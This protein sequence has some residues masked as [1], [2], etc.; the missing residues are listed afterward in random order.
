MKKDQYRQGDVFLEK[1]DKIPSEAKRRKSDVLV[2]GEA[3]G[4]AHRL[5]NGLI[6]E[7][8]PHLSSDPGQMFV[9][10][11]QNAVLFH[12]EHGQIEIEVGFYI[13]VR[14]R[15]YHGKE[16]RLVID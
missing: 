8:K 9:E 1:I 7:I 13:L 16:N 11:K 4:H 3:T 15:E 14:Q 2:E 10:A 5:K 6:Y 12:E